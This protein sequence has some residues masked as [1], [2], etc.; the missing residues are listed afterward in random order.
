MID[1]GHVMLCCADGMLD[2]RSV[3]VQHVFG[4]IKTFPFVLDSP[5]NLPLYIFLMDVDGYVSRRGKEG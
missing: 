3:I 5:G 1:I 4:K 2:I